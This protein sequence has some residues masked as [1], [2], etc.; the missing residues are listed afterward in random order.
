MHSKLRNSVQHGKRI[1]SNITENEEKVNNNED[2]VFIIVV[3][4]GQ[5]KGQNTWASFL[6][7]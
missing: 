6:S 5:S 7:C 3:E 4:G 1:A 2:Q